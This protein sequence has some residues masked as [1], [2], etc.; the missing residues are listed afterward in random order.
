[1]QT[2]FWRK[3][4][5]RIKILTFSLPPGT[6]WSMT[7]SRSQGLGLG[8]WR[9]F[10]KSFNYV[11]SWCFWNDYFNNFMCIYLLKSHIPSM[12]LSTLRARRIAI[13]EPLKDLVWMLEISL[14]KS[15]HSPQY[16][17]VKCLF[18]L[19]NPFLTPIELTVIE[20]EY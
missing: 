12:P 1:M 7:H 11:L 9:T 16:M 13:W 8:Q 2:E 15:N 14:S 4:K 5:N 3:K 19:L 20:N 10:L 6:K 18:I 17:E